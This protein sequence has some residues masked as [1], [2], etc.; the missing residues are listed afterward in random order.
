MRMEELAA[1]KLRPLA[2][3]DFEDL[4]VVDTKSRKVREF[5]E[6]DGLRV[7]EQKGDENRK[8]NPPGRSGRVLH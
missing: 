3:N 6:F 7:T 8:G 2:A 1:G 5:H 4:G